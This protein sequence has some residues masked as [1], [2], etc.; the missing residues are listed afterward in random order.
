MH[1]IL[2]GH[3]ADETLILHYRNDAEIAGGELAKSRRERFSF[4]GY[5]KNP[6]HHSLHIAVSF[7]AERFQNLLFRNHAYHIAAADH[8]KIILQ[9]MDSFV[10]RVLQRVSW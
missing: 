9:A 7:D 4:L 6:V 1:Q 10:E 2:Q 3:D 8:R 5:F